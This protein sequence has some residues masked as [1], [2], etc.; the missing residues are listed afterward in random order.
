M[1]LR[2]KPGDTPQ[3]KRTKFT[4]R[5]GNRDTIRSFS[6]MGRVGLDHNAVMTRSTYAAQTPKNMATI[7]ATTFSKLEAMAE[8][9]KNFAMKPAKGGTPAR[10][11]REITRFVDSKGSF[12]GR[13]LISS[14]LLTPFS[15]AKP[16]SEIIFDN[17][18]LLN[19]IKNVAIAKRDDE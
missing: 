15:S 10:E 13:P 8:I 11:R 6:L 2:T 16:I 17:A 3:I 12:H 4:M 7:I 14:I 5:K 9:T 1:N 18:I 19:I